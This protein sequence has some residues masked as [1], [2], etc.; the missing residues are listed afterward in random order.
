M[1][2]RVFA[3]AL[4]SLLLVSL[5]CLFASCN[6]GEKPLEPEE[7]GYAL[8]AD[9]SYYVV[10]GVGRPESD[11][12]VVLGTHND[13]PVREIGEG[14]FRDCTVA[15]SIM[16][17]YGIEKIGD[18]AFE[19]C[20]AL[21]G[22]NFTEDVTELGADAFAG[23]VK[24]YNCDLGEGMKR[25][26]NGAFTNCSNLGWVKIYAGIESIGENVFHGCATFH[27]VY[28]EGTMAEWEAVDK[29][30]SW[31]QGLSTYKVVCSDGEIAK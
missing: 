7:I 16:V 25:I 27:T 28:F 2:K 12:I 13:L 3:L 15:T 23:C 17:D 19:G 5:L 8:S 11:H 21:L 29:A 30:A 26:G 4:A 18:E 20:T 31:D 22:M 14:A 6:G 1:K 10:T 24:M 9:K